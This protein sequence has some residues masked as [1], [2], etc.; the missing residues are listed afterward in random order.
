[1]KDFYVKEFP[2][3]L[4]KLYAAGIDANLWPEFISALSN[5]F[6]DSPV[7]LHFADL[8]GKTQPL[9]LGVGADEKAFEDY[10][11]HFDAVNPYPKIALEKYR[12]GTAVCAADCLPAEQA[13]KTE[14]YNDWMRSNGWTMHH[15]GAVL[16]NDD[17]RIGVISIS[18]QSANA[19]V[20]IQRD[21]EYLAA[22][23]PHITRA[24]EL[25]QLQANL[26]A[27]ETNIDA[28]LNYI[29]AAAFVLEESGRVIS[30]NA[31]AKQL[32]CRETVL[33]LDAAGRPFSIHP[34][35]DDRL[36]AA[37]ATSQTGTSP[38]SSDIIQ[39]WSPKTSGRFAGWVLC[40]PTPA[41]TENSLKLRLLEKLSPN[42]KR[43]LLVK[44]LA[45]RIDIPADTIG[46]LF[47][48]SPAEAKL[49][50]ALAAGQALA[51]YAKDTG[52][53]RNTVKSQL[54]ST[55]QKLHVNSQAELLRLISNLRD[56]LPNRDL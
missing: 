10:E 12:P 54:A 42:P 47:N 46:S 55:F 28:H 1:M 3:L 49:V 56:F 18:P 25:N 22:L 37:L 33:L 27:A 38:G 20:N 30:M 32:I 31:Q 17:N 35:S 4:D 13:E 52:V 21:L 16:F 40:Y 36:K 6:A 41:A 53:K 45:T 2:L 9:V 15:L 51:D 19:S 48:L 44:S 29:Q 43:V 26:H 24:I 23:T 8:Q 50:A 34:P 39:L 5:A 14:F 11:Q 7:A